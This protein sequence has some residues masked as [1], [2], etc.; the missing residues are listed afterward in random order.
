MLTFFTSCYPFER[1]RNIIQRNAIQSWKK[2]GQNCEIILMGIEVGVMEVA[3]EFGV[4]HFTE[5]QYDKFGLP[6]VSSIFRKAE[7]IA[8]FNFLCY[9]NADIIFLSDFLPAIQR[10]KEK[11]QQ[12]LVVGQRWDTPISEEI[13]FNDVKWEEKMR[14]A[15]KKR[16]RLHGTVG[17][18]YFVFTKG[19]W[20]N[21][22]D[23]SLARR[24]F[25]NWLLADQVSKGN[26]TIDATSCIS[27][28]HQNHS[29]PAR[30]P[31]QYIKNQALAKTGPSAGTSRCE[32]ILTKDDLIKRA[33]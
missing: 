18:D 27:I 19:L 15:V 14:Q 3:K 28:V 31:E 21:I 6:L 2:L 30:L 12:F 26:A 9:V 23:F 32:W 13:D 8:Q 10:V 25:D 7:E 1:K 24:S 17:I 29:R 11:F 20:K 4:R 33:K 5:I 16:G 22:P